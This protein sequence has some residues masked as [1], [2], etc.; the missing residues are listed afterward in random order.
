MAIFAFYC[1]DGEEAH[2]IRPRVREEHFAHIE[3]HRGD[4]MLGGPLKRGGEAI[5][6][7]ILIAAETELDARAIFEADPY[8]IAG[9][10]QSINAT[11]FVPLTGEWSPDED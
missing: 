10:W 1:R 11:E 3:A 5:G 7:L 8:F 2:R 6:S 4:Y 9:V